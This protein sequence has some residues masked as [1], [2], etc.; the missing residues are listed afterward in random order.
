MRGRGP[1]FAFLL[2]AVALAVAAVAAVVVVL[3]PPERVAAIRPAPVESAPAAP[4]EPFERLVPP[5]PAAPPPVRAVAPIPRQAPPPPVQAPPPNAAEKF[6]DSLS[7]GGMWPKAGDEQQARNLCADLA[8]GESPDEYVQGT[9]RKSPQLS[10][11]EA[12]QVVRDAIAA[13]CPQYG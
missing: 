8:N 13:Y 6:S 10:P 7:Q 11:T 9:L 4:P 12:A 2:S 5:P 3:A 1:L